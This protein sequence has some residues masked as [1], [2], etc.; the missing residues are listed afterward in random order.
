MARADGRCDFEY[1]AEVEGWGSNGTQFSTNR[2]FASLRVI[3]QSEATRWLDEALETRR[4]LMMRLRIL[5]RS[6][7]GQDSVAC[8]YSASMHH[9]QTEYSTISGSLAMMFTNRN[10]VF[11]L[12]FSFASSFQCRAGAARFYASAALPSQCDLTQ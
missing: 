6:A 3:L 9:W 4:Q 2:K 11:L 8:E 7:C 10:D 12:P 5:I 1:E